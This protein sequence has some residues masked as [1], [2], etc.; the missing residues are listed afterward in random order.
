MAGTNIQPS[1]TNL[2][3]F[4]EFAG[5]K[6]L[7]KKATAGAYKKAA[8]IILGIIDATEASDLAK[9]DL[10]D[11]FYRHRNKAA[12]KIVPP[13]LKAYETRTRAAVNNFLEYIKDPTTWKPGIQQRPSKATKSAST[14]EKSKAGKITAEKDN[15]VEREETTKTPSIHIDFQIHI[16]PEATPEQIDQIFASMRQYLYPPK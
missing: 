1:R 15:L 16:S 4:L 14:K 8:N 12:G 3:E 11:V 10:N 7:M 13:T 2:I 6:G 5:D 9:I